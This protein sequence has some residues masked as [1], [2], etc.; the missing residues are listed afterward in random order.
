MACKYA[1]VVI[2]LLAS[3]AS[4]AQDSTRRLKEVEVRDKK[5]GNFGFMGQVDGMKIGAGKKTE[6][7]SIEQLTVN[8]ATNNTRQV[9]AKVAGL[10]IFENDGSGLQL[11]IGGRGLDPN[12]TSNFN[13]RQNGYDISAD[14]LGYPE[15]YYTPPVEALRRI[16]IIKGAASLQYGTQFGGLL[17]FEMRQPED[18]KK[19]FSFE[20]RQTLGSWGFF[21]SYNSIA[22]TVGKLSYFA[23]AQYKRGNG[24]RPNSQFQ[25]LNA[26]ADMHYHLSEKHMFGIEYTHLQYL[27]Q[28]PGGL[29]D[30]MF[31]ADPRQSNRSRNWFAV[32]WNLLDVEWDYRLGSRTRLQTRAYGLLASRDALGFR[33]NRPSQADNGGTRDLIKGSFQNVALESRFLHNY[34]GGGQLQT[35]LTGI[36]V[37]NG[38]SNSKQGYVNN[39]SGA[40]FEFKSEGTEMLS[41]YTFPNLN[42]AWFA[43]HI[44]RLNSKWQLT[45]GVRIEYIRTRANGLYHNRVYDLRDSVVSDKIVNEHRILPRT[46]VIG[47][48]GTG[49]RF[50]PRIEAY[51]NISQNYRSVTF[52]D[53]RVVNPSF[54]IDYGITD[55][56]GWSADLGFRGNAQDVFRFDANVFYLYYGNR[57]G[58]YFY[59]KDNTQ[60]VRR[61]GNVGVAQIYGLETFMELDLLRLWNSNKNFGL[62][63]YNNLS[64]TEAEYT[65]SPIKNIEGSRVEYVPLINWK[66]GLQAN[67]KNFRFTYQFSSLSDQYADATNAKTG[68]YSAVNGLVPAY[69]LMDLS[70]A[71]TYNRL[72]IEATVNN[73][74]NVPY[75]TRRATGYPGPGIIPGD[76]RGFY[77]TAGIKL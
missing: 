75:F 58:E 47:G 9:Y 46:F 19:K 62:T 15:S 63:I 61:R 20:S 44:I 18:A 53:I 50:S 34:Y 27:A 25:S 65:R 12:R 76:G 7:I 69:K 6:I 49:Y 28:Q 60:V 64:L 40:D 43:E 36:R 1:F 70:A 77:L 55:E 24:W 59:T 38:Y 35:L 31:E 74:A 10:N 39:G 29:D 67:Y 11:S 21:G 14:A 32:K 8:K 17:N 66:A 3:L 23:Y 22:G 71:Y 30:K 33:P 73:L 45:P 26:Y 51:G 2:A 72:S 56:K 57:I 42:L 13:V 54:E 5:Q 4:V 48:I 52:S 41:E 37:Y 16:E 68:G